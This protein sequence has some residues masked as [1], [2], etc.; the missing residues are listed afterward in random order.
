M[1]MDASTINRALQ[2]TSTDD[3]EFVVFGR[4]DRCVLVSDE[5]SMNATPLMAALLTHTTARHIIF[6]GDRYQLQPL[7]AGSPFRDMIA[8]GVIPTT[9]LTQNYRTNC[10]GIFALCDD[11][12]NGTISTETLP[13]YLAL[14]GVYYVPCDYQS[15]AFMV[16]E[17]YADLV[18]KG[19]SPG[20]SGFCLHTI[21]A[22]M[23]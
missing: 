22:L 13:E 8:S 9:H 19:L 15:R 6:V 4:I 16:A 23:G 10:K 12:L 21:P 14:G 17:H 7:G 20:A 2:M 18:A 3:D 5:S 1:M 11:I